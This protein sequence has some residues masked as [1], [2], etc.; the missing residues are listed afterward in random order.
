MIGLAACEGSYKAA[1]MAAPA[2]LHQ[3]TLFHDYNEI[4]EMREQAG[5]SKGAQMFADKAAA[6][7]RG[8]AVEPIKPGALKLGTKGRR[9]LG[10]TIYARLQA[11]M[12]PETIDAMPAE[13]AHAQAYYDCLVYETAQKEH[14]KAVHSCRRD[15]N[16]AII[17]LEKMHKEAAAGTLSAVIHSYEVYFD[18]NQTALRDDA[19]ASLDQIAAEVPEYEPSDITVTGHADRSG[20]EAANRKIAKK[21]AI[22]VSKALSAKG[23]STRVIDERSKG[24]ADP[25]VPTADGD[26]M[27]ANRRV[28]IDFRK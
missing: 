24:E 17:R 9:A 16:K 2:G 27:E 15:W 10:N 4:A 1:D 23:V 8:R 13:T 5:D 3:K 22:A 12:S 11:H 25:A 14:T 28:V 18:W 19:K 26:R 7:A 6:V 21:R 20:N